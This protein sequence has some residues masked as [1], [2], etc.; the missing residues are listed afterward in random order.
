MRDRTAQPAP[1]ELRRTPGFGAILT[2]LR[3]G[4][5]TKNL[6]VFAAPLFAVR[7]AEPAIVT[8]TLL[9]FLAFCAVSSAG[10]I[11]ND[12]RDRAEDRAHPVKAARPITSGLVG[13]GPALGLA[14]VLTF[15]ALL[16]GAVS[17]PLVAV[18]V[19]AYALL[20]LVYSGPGK[21]LV[22]LDV[23]IIAT[24]FLL[25][26]LAGAAAG[27][28]PS[29]PWFLA[30]TLLLALMLGF[31]KRRS[32]LALLGAAGASTRSTLVLYTVPMLDQ[33]LATLAASA[34]VLYAIYCVSIGARLHTGDMILTWPLVLFGLV[35]Y[36][37][38]SHSNDKPPDELLV[39]DRVLALVSLAFV[40][41]A[42][43]VLH[44]HTHLIPPVTF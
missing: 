8:H 27:N 26:A 19:G 5:W 16:L 14:T 23:F 18:C 33:V 37:Q 38:V 28:V 36:L 17:A 31:G 1:A 40:A 21:R 44:F 4:Q 32:E 25:R 30:L 6:L 13:T 10:Y 29:S 9:A 35:R 7:L 11:Y 12:W 41:V 34:I 43:A 42:A 15:A 2:L 39:T 22:P 3:P 24:G 20:M